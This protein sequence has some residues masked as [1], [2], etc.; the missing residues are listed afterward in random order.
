MKS[1]LLPE[2]RQAWFLEQVRK[3]HLEAPGVV[4]AKKTGVLE[5]QISHL[6]KGTRPV[7]E[8]FLRTFCQAFKIDYRKVDKL[9]K[10]QADKAVVEEDNMLPANLQVKA[11]KRKE[12]IILGKNPN[13]RLK[14]EQYAEAFGDWQGLPM[15]NT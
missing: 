15:Y 1:T 9:I 11:S 8:N 2:L 12:V 7:T 5:G 6:L 10:Q 14:P 3:M 13:Q 4:I